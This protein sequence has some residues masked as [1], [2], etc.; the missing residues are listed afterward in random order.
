MYVEYVQ[1][2]VFIEFKAKADSV[3]SQL[4]LISIKSTNFTVNKTSS[5][6]LSPDFS[7]AG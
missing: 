7:Y 3:V 1:N 6:Q 2:N 5:R 4:Y